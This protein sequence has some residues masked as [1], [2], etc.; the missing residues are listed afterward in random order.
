[1]QTPAESQAISDLI[2]LGPVVTVLLLAIG[3]LIRQLNKREATIEKKDATIEKLNA[4]LV[5]LG[6]KQAETVSLV[7]DRLRRI[8]Y[9][10]KLRKRLN[11]SASHERPPRQMEPGE[12]G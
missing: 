6:E 7:R 1:M 2:K 12:E 9:A 5:A 4:G 8:E 11:D 3:Y 10:L